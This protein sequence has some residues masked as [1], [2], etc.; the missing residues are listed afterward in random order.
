V[1]SDAAKSGKEDDAKTVNL[2]PTHSMPALMKAELLSF[3]GD[4]LVILRRGRLFTVRIGDNSLK[5]VDAINAYAP[6][7]DPRSDWYD[8]MLVSADTVVVIGY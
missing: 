1:S 7:V 4:H 3:T 6:G 5:P 8:E 2:L